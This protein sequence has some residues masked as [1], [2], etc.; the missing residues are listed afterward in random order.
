METLIRTTTIIDTDTLI[1]D[2]ELEVLFD[3]DVLLPHSYVTSV[4]LWNYCHI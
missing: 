3:N 1:E 2:K 4:G